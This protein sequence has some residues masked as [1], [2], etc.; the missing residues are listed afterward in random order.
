MKVAVEN[1]KAFK[2][3]IWYTVSNFLVKG[4]GFI[5]TPIFTRLLT[6]AEFGLFNNYTSWLAIISIIVTLNLDSTLI[7]ARYDYEDDFDGYIFSVL[8]LSSLST[9]FCI[10]ILNAF[11]GF[12]T[13]VFEMEG[14]YINAMMIYLLFLPAVNL[15]QARE[16]YFFE[17][18]KTVIV[19]LLVS[20]GTAL[21]S[22]L[23]VTE[24]ED[25]LFGRIIGSVVPT[26]FLGALLYVFFIRKGRKIKI[27]YWK[28]ALP[29]CLPFIPHL[30]SLNLLNS[31]DRVMITKWCGAEDTAVYSLAYTCGSLVTLLMVSMNGAFAPWLG[32]KL[33]LQAYDE[34]KEFSKKYVLSFSYLAVGIMLIAPE[35]LY[36]LGGKGYTEAK[37]VMTPI[38]MGCLCQ[39]LYTMFVNVEQFKKKTIGMAFASVI[40]ALVNY[41]LNAIFIPKVGYLAAA[42]TTLAGYLCLLLIHM[43]L[44]KKIKYDNVY[45]YRLIIGV[46]I[47]GIIIT[48]FVSWLYLHNTIRYICIVAYIVMG[49]FIIVRYKKNILGFIK[50]VIRK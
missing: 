13:H 19:S 9:T 3:G 41:I 36:I 24:L 5:T 32:E 38:S 30:L 31:M 37:Y 4:I 48:L 35:V 43:S 26:V 29:I 47:I 44:V 22:V 25:R 23:L 6:K 21:I 8:V 18:K 40:A 42:Y 28:Y 39:F 16:R 46:V 49:L 2:S 1:K 33:N 14:I 45:D 10:I 27:E 20:I 34:I 11:Q 15:F 17:Y 7:S 12:F 50:G